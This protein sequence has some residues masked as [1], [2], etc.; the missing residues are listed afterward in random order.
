MK[1]AGWALLAAP[2]LWGQ[3]SELGG[4]QELPAPRSIC[5]R[6]AAE[7]SAARARAPVTD[8]RTAASLLEEAQRACPERTGLLLEAAAILARARAPQEA[9][10]L[11]RRFLEEVPESV[12]GLEV[13]ARAQ[14]LA[15]RF[16]AAVQTTQRILAQ[17]ARN[18]TALKLQGN[19]RYFLGQA[20]EAEAT[21]LRL[22]DKH[23][24][25]EEGAYMLGRIYYQ[26]HRFSLAAGQFQ[27]AL[28]LNPQSYKAHDNL[29]LCYEALGEA[30][31]AVRHFL[32]AIELVETDH[33]NYDWPYANLASLLI[34]QDDPKRGFD[35]ASAAARRNPGSARNFYLG[36]KALVRAGRPRE[37][38]KWLQR[39]VA[40]DPSY[41]PPWYLLGQAYQRLGDSQA[42]GRALARFQA[43][44]A[45]APDDPR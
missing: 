38:V 37:A 23:P 34:D 4:L 17:D 1:L 18:A 24:A 40:I 22:L 28:R 19:A 39:S 26:E 42:A 44:K 2:S 14:L 45:N 32:A 16:E 8:P 30:E 31:R 20:A 15:Q 7:E 12:A 21:L 29:A 25:D 5:D 33:P 3:P 36:G 41:P 10:R 35:A 27:K 6:A 9:I 11:A 43:A 13:L